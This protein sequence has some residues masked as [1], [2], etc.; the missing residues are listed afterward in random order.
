MI[1]LQ[2]GA[3]AFLKRDGHYLLMKR[4]PERKIAPN[5]WS[6]VGGHMEPQELNDPLAA[7]LREIHEET[8]ISQDHIFNLELRYLIIRRAK[9]VIRQ[10]YIYFGATDVSELT[11][12]NEG[13]LHWIPESE[14][15]DREFTQTFAAML[16]H[17]IH[18]PAPQ[19][20]IVVGTAESRAGRLQMG[21][22]T[23]EDFE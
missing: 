3:A 22:S 15:L 21:W 14:L 8:G 6:C 10:N 7:C 12:T 5:V 1:R 23:V 18:T 13:T 9:D 17:Y 2:H 16:D 11:A 19:R 20:R 4:S